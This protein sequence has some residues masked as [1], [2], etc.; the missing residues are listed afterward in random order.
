MNSLAGKQS[1]NLPESFGEESWAA[2]IRQ[3]HKNTNVLS[4]EKWNK[5]YLRC[6]EFSAGGKGDDGEESDD[7]EDNES[8]EVDISD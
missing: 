8:A 7:D 5:I 1:K 6:R 2:V 3:H 4:K